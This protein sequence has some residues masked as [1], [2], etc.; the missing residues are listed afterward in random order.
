MG[1]NIDQAKAIAELY[2]E[3]KPL[4]KKY[5]RRLLINPALTDEVIHDAFRIACAN[6]DSLLQSTNPNGFGENQKIEEEVKNLIDI[7]KNGFKVPS[8]PDCETCALQEICHYPTWKRTED[9]ISRYMPNSMDEEF[10]KFVLQYREV[11][12]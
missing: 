9:C 7:R 4:L 11:A 3:L 8:C 5:A 10:G 6:A 12:L 2:T 1:L